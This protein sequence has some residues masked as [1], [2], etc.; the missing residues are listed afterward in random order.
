[1]LKYTS[2]KLKLLLDYVMILFFEKGILGGL[3]QV[4]H[5]YAEANNPYMPNF[6]IQS[7]SPFISY[8]DANNLYGHAMDGTTKFLHGWVGE[9]PLR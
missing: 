8:L 7:E 2:V 3:F 4:I 6:Y 1:M 9:F 5:R